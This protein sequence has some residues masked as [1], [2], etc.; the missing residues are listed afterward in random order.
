MI[1]ISNIEN[2]YISATAQNK[3]IIVSDFFFILTLFSL[4]FLVRV[5]LVWHVEPPLVV[6][7]KMI[8]YMLP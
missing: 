7:E 6:S 5:F 2:E 1:S 3:L 8:C 4:P